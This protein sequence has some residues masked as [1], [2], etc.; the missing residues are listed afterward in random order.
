M[1]DLRSILRAFPAGT[2][3]I[4]IAAEL[5]DGPA[6]LRVPSEGDGATPDILPVILETPDRGRGAAA[7]IAEP[8]SGTDQL[9]LDRVQRLSKARGNVALKPREWSAITGLSARE[10]RRAIAADALPHAEKED[11]RDHGARVVTTEAMLTYLTTVLAVE[12]GHV[13]A[14]SWWDAVRGRP[15]AAREWQE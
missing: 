14:P 5:P 15:A 10:L 3:L 12:R 7:D 1:T 8:V 11:G 2:K 4:V 9:L 6:D 13:S